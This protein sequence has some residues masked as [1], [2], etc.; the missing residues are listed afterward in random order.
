MGRE[1]PAFP[2]CHA[3]NRYRLDRIPPRDRHEAQARRM[4]DFDSSDGFVLPGKT[5]PFRLIV[6]ASQTC[7]SYSTNVL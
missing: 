6:T 7:E 2:S 5:S 1:S 3:T 4:P